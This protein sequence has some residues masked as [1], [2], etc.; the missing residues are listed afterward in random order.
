MSRQYIHTMALRIK[1]I[2]FSLA[3]MLLLSNCQPQTKGRELRYLICKDSCQY[4][5]LA[6]KAS[7]DTANVDRFCIDGE[8]RS[9]LR[10]KDGLYHPSKSY[11]KKWVISNDSILILKNSTT[12][13]GTIELKMNKQVKDTIY[14]HVINKTYDQSHMLIK[15]NENL[16]FS[17]D[18]ARTINVIDL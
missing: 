13:F 1:S 11:F 15:V 3:L 2:F 4:W 8:I 18:S 16:K 6:S 12:N 10:Q 5:R 9:Y 17:K 7:F 14:F